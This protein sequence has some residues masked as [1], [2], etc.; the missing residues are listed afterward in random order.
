MYLNVKAYLQC[1]RITFTYFQM[2][3]ELTWSHLLLHL[4]RALGLQV[5]P[6][7]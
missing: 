5:G 1:L 4:L 2:F 6:V 3:Y 7:L